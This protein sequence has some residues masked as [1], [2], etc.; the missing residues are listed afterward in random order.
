MNRFD[1]NMTVTITMM[2]R[3]FEAALQWDT[4]IV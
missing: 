2:T 3:V 4:F 1:F